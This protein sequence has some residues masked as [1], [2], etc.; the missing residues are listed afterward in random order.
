MGTLRLICWIP[1]ARILSSALTLRE[2]LAIWVCVS[3]DHNSHSHDMFEGAECS[4]LHRIPTE[5]DVPRYS[6]IIK[7]HHCMQPY[8]VNRID[9]LK[10]CFGRDRFRSH[11]DDMGGVGSPFLVASLTLAYVFPGAFDQDCRSLY[12]G[13]LSLFENIEEILWKEFGEWGTPEV[14]VVSTP[15]CPNCSSLTCGAACQRY[16]AVEHW[17][18]ALPQPTQC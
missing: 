12:I 7:F 2:E 6:T 5:K 18:C 10:D 13:G 9:N 3:I 15:A 17:L 11:R 16:P 4:F 14:C 8:T 1:R